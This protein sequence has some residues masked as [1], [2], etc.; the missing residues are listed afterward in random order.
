MASPVSAI[1]SPTSLAAVWAWM[2]SGAER[3]RTAAATTAAITLFG[4]DASWAGVRSIVLGRP[5]HRAGARGSF[6]RCGH[7][8]ALSVVHVPAS[9]RWSRR[10]SAKMRGNRDLNPGGQDMYDLLLKGGTVVDPSAGL[11]GVHDIAVE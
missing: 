8:S 3:S 10:T 9:A 1:F 7:C 11:D 6:S 2:A 4:M 5:G